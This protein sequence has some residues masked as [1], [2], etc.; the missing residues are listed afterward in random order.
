M[1]SSRALCSAGLSI[2]LALA[3]G[4]GGGEGTSGTSAGTGGTG[5]GASASSTGTGGT[6]GSAS[7]SSAS[8]SSGADGGPLQSRRVF[9]TSK[10]YQGTLGGLAGADMECQK[11]ADAANLGGTWMAWLS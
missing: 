7:A 2:G 8:S 9:V 1:R 6:G 5:G 3:V 11:L 10:T 4:C